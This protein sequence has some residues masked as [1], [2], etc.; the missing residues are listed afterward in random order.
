MADRTIILTWISDLGAVLVTDAIDAA[1]FSARVKA[2]AGLSGSAFA[3]E[4]LD[5]TRVAGESVV[6]SGDLDIFATPSGLD[7]ETGQVFAVLVAVGLSI[8]APRID[9]PHRPSARRARERVAAA[10]EAAMDVASGLGA[11]GADLF[12]WLSGVTGT[13]IRLLSNIAAN[14]VPIVR[15]ETGISQPS[16]VLAYRLYGDAGRAE[17]LVE[18]AGSTTPM[19]MPSAFDALES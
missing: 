14:A 10:A 9:W 6:A 18:V 12:A 15:V 4:A 2:A 3:R 13:S 5:L 1:D 8:A 7:A 17:Q 19:L 16:S 11:E